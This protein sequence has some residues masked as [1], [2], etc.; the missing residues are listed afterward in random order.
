MISGLSLALTHSYPTR[1]AALGSRRPKNPAMKSYAHRRLPVL[2]SADGDV[3]LDGEAQQ[4]AF[5][6]LLFVA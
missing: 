2:D 5:L 6:C 4:G 1:S 3:N